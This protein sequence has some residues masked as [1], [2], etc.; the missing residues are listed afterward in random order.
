MWWVSLSEQVP[1]CE[2]AVPHGQVQSRS[3]DMNHINVP[4]V[5]V[6]REQVVPILVFAH[7]AVSGADE[8]TTF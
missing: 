3:G 5:P 1:A 4:F 7:A 2:D 6:K 8:F